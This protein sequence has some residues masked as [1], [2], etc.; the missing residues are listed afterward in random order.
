MTEEELIARAREH[1]AQRGW[2]WREP[3]HVRPVSWHGAAAYQIE[4]HVG[5]R[6]MNVSVVVAAAD[7][8]ILNAAY[9]SR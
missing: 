7:G 4:T 1:A 6:G 3:I 5:F 8:S 2:S 9:L